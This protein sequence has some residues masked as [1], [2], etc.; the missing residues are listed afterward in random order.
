MF[1][2]FANILV[3]LTGIDKLHLGKNYTGEIGEFLIFD[4][5]LKGEERRSIEKYLQEKWRININMISTTSAKCSNGAFITSSGICDD[6]NEDCVS[7]PS[8]MTGVST[9]PSYVMAGSDSIDCDETGYSGA[10]N[11]TCIA[12]NFTATSSCTLP[13]M[14]CSGGTKSCVGGGSLPSCTGG[15]VIHVFTASDTFS[16]TTGD[17]IANLEYLGVGAGG[18]GGLAK[19]LGVNQR[20]AGGGGGGGE[21]VYSSGNSLVA[22]D[23]VSV[24]VGDDIPST[25]KGTLGGVVVDLS[26]HKGGNGG[27]GSNGSGYQGED[28]G[29]AG[30]GGGGGCRSGAGGCLGGTGVT[31]GTSGIM[32]EIANGGR[33]GANNLTGGISS[34]ITGT[35]LTYGRA[36][37]GGWGNGD[38]GTS[39]TTYGSGGGGGGSGAG[40]DRNGVQGIPGV[41]IFSYS[42]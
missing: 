17:S 25:I 33:G 9:M 28:G 42:Y 19:V 7:L 29:R 3:V 31:N 24:V 14:T 21:V 39:N 23:S 8:S 12:G 41:V 30:G 4:R 2:I 18:D 1:V 13:P 32:A 38:Q 6:T 5:A 40:A 26:F 16:C 35:T 27:A 15:K 11:Y 34:S 10:V 37:N 22:N 20:W 36:G